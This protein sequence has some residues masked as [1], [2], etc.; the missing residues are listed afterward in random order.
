MLKR[1]LIYGLA[2]NGRLTAHSAL[3]TLTVSPH[4]IQTKKWNYAH[5][6]SENLTRVY[7]RHDPK[8]LKSKHNSFFFLVNLNIILHQFCKSVNTNCII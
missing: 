3:S 8:L 7:Q 5:N 1:M 2:L 6:N 4:F